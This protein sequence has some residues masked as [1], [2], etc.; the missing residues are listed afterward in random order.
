MVQS[1]LQLNPDGTTRFWVYNVDVAHSEMCR[2]ICRLDLLIFFVESSTFEKYIKNF[3]ILDSLM[4]LD[5]LLLE[6]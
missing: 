6:T 4:C 5:K 2:L 1:L 3:I